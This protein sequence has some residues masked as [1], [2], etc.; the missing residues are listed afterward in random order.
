MA[1][2]DRVVRAS[3][4]PLQEQQ[5]QGLQPTA[6]PPSCPSSAASGNRKRGRENDEPGS[7]VGIEESQ[8]WSRCNAE[9]I[10][11]W[12]RQV[13]G[14]SSSGGSRRKG[15]Q[16]DT[17]ERYASVLLSDPEYWM[18]P[19]LERSHWKRLS[20]TLK[21]EIAKCLE[22]CLNQSTHQSHRLVFEGLTCDL[23]AFKVL[24][25]GET[26]PSTTDA[27]DLRFV[28]ILGGNYRRG[29][30]DSSWEQL[31]QRLL[32]RFQVASLADLWR[33]RE[34]DQRLQKV[35]EQHLKD[36]LP[37]SHHSAHTGIN[38]GPFLLATTTIPSDCYHRMMAITKSNDSPL[39]E[40]HRGYRLP[41]E[42]E[43][44]Y[45]ARGGGW[46]MLFPYH[47]RIPD[48]HTIGTMATTAGPREAFDINARNAFGLKELAFWPELCCN[49]GNEHD[50]NPV[51]CW[52][53]GGDVWTLLYHRR[54][55]LDH[56]EGRVRLVREVFPVAH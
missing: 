31:A 8:G 38:V 50:P 55:Q 43:W 34:R 11:S 18:G 51:T 47:C 19:R 56:Q 14:G 30:S 39:K 21:E 25:S 46:D 2:K 29:M 33:F 13:E 52:R 40:A 41:S 42:V 20:K 53:G 1:P 5:N 17:L 45:A 26:A 35:L 16:A 24:P 27:Q 23:P 4:R 49:H 54:T 36:P 6:G 15:L 12:L 9:G 32:E 28:L 37:P 10:E 48:D 3:Q 7:A 22:I 44:E